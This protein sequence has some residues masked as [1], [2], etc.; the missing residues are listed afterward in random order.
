MDHTSLAHLEIAREQRVRAATM[1]TVARESRRAAST[2]L[3]SAGRMRDNARV[4]LIEAQR[5]VAAGGRHA[6]AGRAR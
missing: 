3:E 6:G 5:H 4:A 1:N 2:M